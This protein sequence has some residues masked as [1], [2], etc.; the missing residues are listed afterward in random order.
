MKDG[1]LNRESVTML[2]K[3]VRD[4]IVNL[5]DKAVKEFNENHKSNNEQLRDYIS[6]QGQ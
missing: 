3:T 2:Q 1:K 6:N 5:A 4:E